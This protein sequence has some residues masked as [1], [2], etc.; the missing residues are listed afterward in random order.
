MVLKMAVIVHGC[1]TEE[2]LEIYTELSDDLE[3]QEEMTAD[4]PGHAHHRDD[5]P[6]MDARWLIQHDGRPLHN[7][8]S[9]RRPHH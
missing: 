1:L 8:S 7:L 5:L 6:S 4:K 9:V 2:G 3:V